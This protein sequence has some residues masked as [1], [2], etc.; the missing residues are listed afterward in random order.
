MKKITLD[1]PWDYITPQKTLRFPAGEHEVTNEIAAA[2]E[3]AGRIKETNDGGGTGKPGA[4][5]GAGD[6]EE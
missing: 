2:A 5:G 1:K 6:A 4:G 3:T